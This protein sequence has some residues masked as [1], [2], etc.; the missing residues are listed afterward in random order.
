MHNTYSSRLPLWKQ[1]LLGAREQWYLKNY[2]AARDHSVPL[3][4]A[5]S[6]KNTNELIKTISAW[7]KFHGHSSKVNS[8][9]KFRIEKIQFPNGGHLKKH[10][11]LTHKRNPDFDIAAV[12]AGKFL[13]IKIKSKESIEASCCNSCEIDKGV[14]CFTVFNMDGFVNLYEKTFES[15]GT[16]LQLFE[17]S[18][19]ADNLQNIKSYD[20]IFKESL[21]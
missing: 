9:S 19:S 10:S 21:S 14:Y 15:N 11:W 16:G 3:P 17:K 12:V 6:E 8:T 20:Q 18:T 5:Y 2:A 4:P 7:L 13:Q 1:K